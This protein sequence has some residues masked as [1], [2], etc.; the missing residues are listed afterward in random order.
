MF[1]VIVLVVAA[2]ASFGFGFFALSTVGT[3]IQLILAFLGI[4]CG[5]ILAGLAA[6]LERLVDRKS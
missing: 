1:M 3:D 2:V 6:I 4:A 5:F